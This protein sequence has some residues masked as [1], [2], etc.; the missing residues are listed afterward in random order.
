MRNKGFLLFF[1]VFLIVCVSGIMLAAVLFYNIDGFEGLS[2]N[3]VML[4]IVMQ[5]AVFI[6]LAAIMLV[7][8]AMQKKENPA[9]APPAYVPAVSKLVMM[10]QSGGVRAECILT[11]KRTLVIG[12]NEHADEYLKYA[13]DGS[14]THEYAVLNLERNYWYIEAVSEL[15][16]VGIRK[17]YD[18]VF[19]RLKSGTLYLIEPNDAIEI[20]GEKIVV[21]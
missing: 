4:I 21:K 6:F 16:N 12:K 2:N 14:V 19:R 11:D 7:F 17:D 9:P 20:A 18:Y 1:T 3:P 15:R 10:D 8:V 13:G 5:N